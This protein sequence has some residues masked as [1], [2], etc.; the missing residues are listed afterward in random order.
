MTP[1]RA[2]HSQPEPGTVHG[3]GPH[4]VEASLPILLNVEDF[5]PSRFLRTRVFRDAGF[6]VIE[7][8]SAREALSAAARQ[9]PAVALIDVHLPDSSGI[10]LC[11]TLKHLHPQLPVLLISAVDLSAEAQQAGLAV[12]AH[13]YLGEPV[14]PTALVESVRRALSG[15][16]VRTDSDTWVVTDAAGTIL[17]ASPLAA[18]LLSGTPRGLLRRSLTVFFEHDRDAWTA[19]MTRAS[20]GER[21]FRSGGLRPKERRPVSVRVEIEKVPDVAPPVLIWTFHP[22]GAD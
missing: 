18:R 7:A 22:D 5:E 20:A 14:T 16:P 11:D 21:V 4:P 2:A 15:P 6:E 8:G 9:R 3:K 17:E 1:D 10:T 13:G 12:G 19:A